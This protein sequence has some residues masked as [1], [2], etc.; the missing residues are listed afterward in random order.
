MI[1]YTHSGKD[2]SEII[3]TINCA[4]GMFNK[5]GLTTDLC[6]NLKHSNTYSKKKT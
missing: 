3:I 6:G 4:L 2:N 1:T 5:T